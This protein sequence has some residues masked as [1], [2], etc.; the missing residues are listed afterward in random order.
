MA[1]DL[2]VSSFPQNGRPSSIVIVFLPNVSP[3]R[4]LG[5]IPVTNG[6]REGGPRQ[7]RRSAR[8][9]NERMIATLPHKR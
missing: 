5:E 3:K 7:A 4:V 6:R 1:K 9:Q 2:P 8:R